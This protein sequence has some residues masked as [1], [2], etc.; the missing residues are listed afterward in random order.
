MEMIKGK[1]KSGIKRNSMRK[2]L[3]VILLITALGQVSAQQ[4]P[5]YSMYMFNPLA[6]NP[7]YAGSLD[8]MQAT[9]LFRK[10]WVNFPGAPST[11][12][13]SFHTPMKNENVGLGVSFINDRVGDMQTNAVMV[14][15]A[16]HLK[17]K[18]S[19]LAFGLQAGMRNFA[20]NLSTIKLDPNGT[21][22]QTFANNI[23]QWDLNFGAGA[24]W[25]SDKWY[26]G[27]SVPHLQNNILS[28]SQLNTPYV[29]RLRTHY[30]LT[31][32][33]VF[34]LSP[35]LKLKPSFLIKQVGGAPIQADFNANLYYLD[36]L[37]IGVSYRPGAAMVFMAEVQLNRNLRLGY[38]FDQ[39]VNGIAGSVG[40]SHELMLRCDFGFNKNKT[41]TP[42]YF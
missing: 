40:G 20:I 10:Q 6:I 8:Q 32:G 11:A 5:M 38:A 24:F 1:S 35:V 13:F 28:N 27:F 36:F 9:G 41:V 25:Y 15:Y 19:R 29:A 42:R 17:F 12:T 18:K 16:Y 22:D 23:S 14:A 2:L 33:Y 3:S 31:A 26:V 21:Y 4:D 30:N 7:A 39:A 34:K 37:G